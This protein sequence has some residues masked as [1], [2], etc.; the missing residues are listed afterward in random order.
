MAKLSRYLSGFELEFGARSSRRIQSGPQELALHIVY[1]PTN[2]VA[3]TN[4]ANTVP[5][6]R[7]ATKSV[8]I[9]QV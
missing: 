7:R 2:Q 4:F 6:S 5:T 3:L 9:V 8:N 1:I